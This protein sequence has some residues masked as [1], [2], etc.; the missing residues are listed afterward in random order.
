VAEVG[1]LGGL[2]VYKIKLDNGLEMKATVTNVARP[3]RSRIGVGDRVWFA[4]PPEAGL[5]LLQ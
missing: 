1:Y 2:S 3:I 5:V 4:F